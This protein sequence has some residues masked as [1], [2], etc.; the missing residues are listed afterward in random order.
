MPD[1]VVY[2]EHGQQSDSFN[3]D[4]APISGWAL[5]QVAFVI[6]GIRELED[7]LSMTLTLCKRI[8]GNDPGARLQRIARGADVCLE[9]KRLIYVTGHTTSATVVRDVG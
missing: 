3:S 7:A 4:D 6:P 1:G 5:T 8:F 9:K 2:A